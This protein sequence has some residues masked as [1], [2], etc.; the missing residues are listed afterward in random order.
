MMVPDS[1]HVVDWKAHCWT[2]I[3]PQMSLLIPI[4]RSELP[5]GAEK[6]ARLDV[7][8][9]RSIAV[10]LPCLG[11]SPSLALALLDLSC[12]LLILDGAHD[13]QM[14]ICPPFEHLVLRLWTDHSDELLADDLSDPFRI[15]RP[16]ISY[17][18]ILGPNTKSDP[19][20]NVL[21]MRCNPHSIGVPGLA[22]FVHRYDTVRV[23][24]DSAH[25]VHHH[26]SI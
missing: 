26:H 5:S 3:G 23:G 21:P 17:Q 6:Q 11:L 2:S 18:G 15:R 7:T 14:W 9:G 22:T 4:A 13:N 25:T 20:E 19:S 12:L 16:Q 24:L 8:V 1:D 10:P